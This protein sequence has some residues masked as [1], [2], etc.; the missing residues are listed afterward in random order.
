M[1]LLFPDYRDWVLPPIEGRDQVKRII[2]FIGR[3]EY[4]SFI[5]HVKRSNKK[6]YRNMEPIDLIHAVACTRADLKRL[7]HVPGIRCIEE[8]IKI[9]IRFIKEQFPIGLPVSQ[10]E[11]SPIHTSPAVTIPRGIKQIQAPKAWKYS[12]GKRVHIGVI[13]TGADYSHPNLKHS[14]G[15]GFNC[16][17]SYAVPNDD[18]GHG[19]HICGTIAANGGESGFKGTAPAAI[20]HPVKAFDK[21]GAAYVSDIIKAIEWCTTN[22]MDIINM[23][24]GMQ[25]RSQALLDAVTNA[26]KKGII[27]VSSAGNEGKR[28]DI[29]YPARF[30]NTIAVGAVD[31]KKRIASFSNRGKQVDFYAPGEKVYSTWLDGKYSLLNGTSMAT[32]HVTGTAA[33]LLSLNPKLTTYQVKRILRQTAVPIIGKTG[34]PMAKK[35]VN[36]FKAVRFLRRRTR[37][38]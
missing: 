27:V 26:V 37:P 21:H 34:K 35:M 23:S 19:T 1:G 6:L 16:L 7:K 22:R 13:D 14:L 12:K 31:K 8:N 38:A 25:T 30:K 32:A 36:A 18:N 28:S 29:D 9:R 4:L 2:R 5:R 33:L 10:P 24:F 20:I 3:Q 17:Q 11:H 15:Q